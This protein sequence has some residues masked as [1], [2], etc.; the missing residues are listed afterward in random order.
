MEELVSHSGARYP[1]VPRMVV[2]KADCSGDSSL[3][4]PKSVIFACSWSLSR[5]FSGFTSQW[6][7]L[8]SQPPWR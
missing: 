5:M 3:D 7:I 4:R 8:W 2:K 1:R 6:I